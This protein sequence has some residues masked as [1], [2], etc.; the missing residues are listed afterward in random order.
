M[1]GPSAG[2]IPFVRRAAG[3]ESPIRK[4]LLDEPLHPFRGAIR[5]YSRPILATMQE[6]WSGYRES[7]PG[8]QLGR[9][10]LYH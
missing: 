4:E 9:L 10:L 7:N 6:G 5:P 1:A 2:R 8:I 3:S